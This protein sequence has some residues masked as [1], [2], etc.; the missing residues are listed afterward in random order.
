[1]M[2]VSGG[3]LLVDVTHDGR[4]IVDLVPQLTRPSEQVG[5]LLQGRDADQAVELLGMLFSICA[6]AHRVAGIRAINAARNQN[7]DRKQQDV[8]E[9]Q[10]AVER[11]R[12]SV[13]RLLLDWHYPCVDD[14]AA[15]QCIRLCKAVSSGL[16]RDAD[17]ADQ[18]VAALQNWWHSIRCLP[19]EQALWIDIHCE[20]W[21]GISLGDSGVPLKPDMAGAAGD[22]PG[23]ETGPIVQSHGLRDAAEVIGVAMKALVSQVD[24]ALQLLSLGQVQTEACVSSAAG[25][26]LGIG[27]ALTARGW[28][29]HEVRLD[30]NRV[31]NWQILAPTDRNFHTEGVLKRRLQGV[32]AGRDQAEALTRDLTLA[33]DPCVAFEVRMNDA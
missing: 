4:R 26:D 11:L 7:T 14:D 2:G 17:E 3:Q 18:A 27:W 29:K 1:M 22:N 10:V 23:R 16:Q 13:M 12:E 31:L 33:I 15:A 28:L 24:E 19:S 5:Q 25:A 32:K 20:R 9:R 30:G 8:Y 21:Q 6:G